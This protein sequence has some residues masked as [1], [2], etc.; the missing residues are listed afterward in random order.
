MEPELLSLCLSSKTLRTFKNIRII[1]LPEAMFRSLLSPV[2]F[3]AALA[4]IFIS[5]GGKKETGLREDSA[6]QPTK[7]PGGTATSFSDSVSEPA[8]SPV[9]IKSPVRYNYEADTTQVS[10]YI[11]CIFQDTKGNLWFGTVGDGACRYDGK[12]LTYFTPQEGFG[13]YSV[14]NIIEDQNGNLWFATSGGISKYDGTGFT[15]F[16][17]K[18]GLNND[19][20]WSLLIDR[21]GTL[22]AGTDAGVCRYDARGKTFSDFSIGLANP[23]TVRCMMEDQAGNI[24]FG[25]SG[26]GVYRYDG[27]YATHLSEKDGLNN[28]FLYGILQDRAGN[29][30]FSTTRGGASRY[31]GKSFTHFTEKEG[32]GGIETW[33]MCE[34]KA[35]NVWICAR[36]KAV[37]Y[38]GRSFTAFT[39]NDGLTDCCVQDIYEDWYGNLWFGSGGGLFRFDGR[40]FV[41]VT[42]KGPW[43]REFR[44][45]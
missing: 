14:Q 44:R 7:D 28:N 40:T 17:K 22:W 26:A 9:V 19:M 18:E 20:A 33:A 15:N 3:V 6:N 1:S 11:R 8:A 39:A 5:C 42:K 35:G 21:S 32:L 31:D 24:W 27:K 34:D 45:S 38:D 37:R 36:G 30:W 43:P 4:V 13:G 10:Q 41:N 25:T 12:T 2:F 16:T 29:T 23:V